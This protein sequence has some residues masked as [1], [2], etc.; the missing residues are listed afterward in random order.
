MV[1]FINDEKHE[2]DQGISVTQLFEAL[3]ILSK[4]GVAVALNEQIVMQKNWQSTILSEKDKLLIISATK[5]G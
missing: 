5:G 1:V 2:V 3:Q 4:Q